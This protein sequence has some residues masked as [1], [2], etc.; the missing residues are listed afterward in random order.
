M[1]KT[2]PPETRSPKVSIGMPVYNEELFIR[3]ALDSLLAQTYGDF[4]IIISD[5]ASTDATA[6][7]CKEYLQRDR[8]IRYIRQS[9]NLGGY[10]NFLFA[11]KEARGEYFM[12]AAADDLW[13]QNCLMKWASVLSTHDDVGLVFSSYGNYLHNSGEVILRPYLAP[14]LS[15]NKS[16]RL[17]QRMLNPCPPM[18]YGLF[19]KRLF[20]PQEFKYFDWNDIFFTNYIASKAKIVVLTDYL[21]YS[22]IKEA[23]GVRAIICADGNRLKTRGFFVNMLSLICKNCSILYSVPLFAILI[24]QMLIFKQFTREK[25]RKI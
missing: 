19:R 4:E 9:Q 15:N 5:N 21:Y 12:W 23:N 13:D 10:H 25:G 11:F 18:I 16:I 2:T 3:K 22:G 7:I 14:C 20:Q 24:K 17:M 1:N 8:R 6:E